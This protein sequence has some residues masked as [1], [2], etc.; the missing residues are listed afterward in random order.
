MSVNWVGEVSNE[1]QV[2]VRCALSGRHVIR[3]KCESHAI[4]ER[5]FGEFQKCSIV[6]V[7]LNGRVREHSDEELSPLGG[8][9][10]IAIAHLKERGIGK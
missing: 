6:V 10:E 8:A 2:Q 9:D 1:W 3:H 7:D 4:A 5:R